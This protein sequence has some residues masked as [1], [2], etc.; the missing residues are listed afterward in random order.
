L[1]RRS[2]SDLWLIRSLASSLCAPVWLKHVLRAAVCAGILV[3]LIGPCLAAPETLTVLNVRVV[4]NLRTD[5]AAIVN[6]LGLDPGST[7]AYSEVRSGL[8][9]V[10]MMGFFDDIRLYTTTG[11]AGTDLTLEVIERP[12]VMTIKISGNKKIGKDDVR[13]KV[14]LAA[15]SS[16]DGRLVDESIRAIKA[17]YKDKGYYLASVSPET[18]FASPTTV[19][20]DFKIE[21]GVKVKVG[22][23]TV[24]GNTVLSARTIR[25]VME[26]K[27]KGWFARKDFN[28]E[29]YDSDTDKIVRLYKD[30]GY[31]NAK[32]VEHRVGLDEA[33]GKADLVI[34]VDE[35]RRV[36]VRSTS[37]D[38]AP[39]EDG[40]TTVSRD[41][42]TA[43]IMLRAGEPYSLSA[44]EK[45][46]EQMYSV[47]GDQGFVYASVDPVE[48]LEGDSL[49]LVFKVNPERAVHVVKVLIEGNET[50]FEKVIRRE[51]MIRPGDILR[52][53]LVERSHR[54][55]F[56]LGYFDNVEVGSQVANDK[57]DIDLVFKVKERQTGVGN[58]GAGYSEEFGI[59]G[60][61][62]FSHENMGWFR[63]FPYLGLGKGQ[64][65]NL[66]WE[67]GKLTQI[68][69]GYRNPWFRDTPTLVGVDIYDTRRE[70]ET[71]TDKRG[72]FG[73]VA[74]KRLPFIDYSRAYLRY[75]LERRELVPDEAKA[76][77]YVKSQ[78]GSRTTSS[79][80]LTMTRNSVDNPFFPRAGSRTTGSAEWAGAW[81]GGS[82]AYQMYLLDNSNFLA[83]PVLNSALVLK[84]RIG[85][86][87]GLGSKGYI[88]VYERFRL[89]GTTLE[90]V[91]GY[92][93][94]EI[95]PEGNAS[96]EGGKFMMTS[97]LEYR[98]PVIKNQAFVRGFLDAGDTWNS[99]RGARPGFLKSGA[100]LGFM[101]EIPMVG[102]IGLDVGYGFDRGKL[103]GGPGWKTHFQ[104]GMS[105]L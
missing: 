104:F 101:I 87:D 1:R 95:V 43:A 9:R 88:P 39:G 61:I 68:E 47:L 81:L 72:G 58:V 12:V 83:V 76:S 55:I 79:V 13:A 75:S 53:S 2:S 32:V 26:T 99:V 71:Y 94:R 44:F 40:E 59:T 67:F 17:L 93:D 4:G 10:F 14:A 28:P 70:Y 7:Y 18:T 23:I 64:S 42:L 63:K 30:E 73:L 25:K 6:T 49:G 24:E 66:R 84:V 62:E 38:L 16:L 5:S 15:G 82:T 20:L 65:L 22:K 50:T 35:G 92:D 56:N 60:F 96:D 105:G 3:S 29:K 74:G 52:R 11:A 98:V 37:V 21:E 8:E 102:Q 33:Q 89:G 85:L 46:V 57:G 77:S 91:R 34:V 54:D 36:Y 97:S 80:T 19:A 69:L 27:E 31:L 51:L 90:S 78:A 41:A 45:S 103:Y 48:S 100:G 86:L